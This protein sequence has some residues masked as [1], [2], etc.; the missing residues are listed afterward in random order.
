[1]SFF[2]NVSIALVAAFAFNSAIAAD[3]KLPDYQTVTLDNGATVLLMPRKDVPLVAA[4]IAVRGG[5]LADAAG[6]E[7]TADLLGEML[8]KGA[9][10]R[11][12]LQFAQTVDGAGGSLGFGSSREAIIANAQFLSKDSALMLSLLADA[13]LRPTMDSAEF[14]KLRKRAIDGIANAKDSD[15]RQLIGTYTGGWLFRGHPYGRSTGGDETSLATIT[16]SDLQAFRQQQMGGDRLIIAI[17]GDFDATAVTAQLKQSFG[18]W[19]KAS[20]GLPAVEAKARETGRRVLLIDKPGAT[21]TY[22]A[23]ANV[24]SKRGDPAEAAQDLVQTAFGGRFTSM[25]NTELRVKSGLT[26][27]A[28]SGIERASQ[29]GPV[30]ISSFTKTETTKAAIDLA[31]ATLDR[32]HKDGLDAATIDSAKRYVAGQY[33]PGLET[34][35]QLAAQLVDMTLYGDSRETIDGYLGNI[36]AAT[37][38]Q[39]AAA[40]AVFPESKDLAIVAIGDAATIRDVIKSYG[41]LTEMKLTD[42]RFSPN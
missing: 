39:I 24:G 40:R 37:P 12:A 29:P 38:A 14:D 2:R 33:A 1:M 18:A 36:A 32:L 16:L 13:L 7:G 23:L 3:I 21:Q 34:A 17:A 6:K 10:S 35:P 41:P 25:L 42:P 9:G 26:Y 5:A 28:R 31:I 22:F 30:A 27:G 11:S 15:P 20:G 4:N 8:S 19:P